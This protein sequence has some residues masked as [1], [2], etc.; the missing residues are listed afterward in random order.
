MKPTT[1][2]HASVNM[3]LQV[4]RQS[5]A[6]EFRRSPRGAWDY[7]CVRQYQLEAYDEQARLFR[8]KEEL[9][10][11]VNAGQLTTQLAERHSSDG[12]VL[13][14]QFGSEHIYMLDLRRL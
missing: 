11:I 6:R 1:V 8:G 9:P 12:Q 14:G 3:T 2:I 10:C 5:I 4:R 13:L 7:S